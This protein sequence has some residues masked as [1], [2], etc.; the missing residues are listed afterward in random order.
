MTKFLV[1]TYNEHLLMLFQISSNDNS[2]EILENEVLKQGGMYC[3]LFI[4][5]PLMLVSEFQ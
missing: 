2:N 5:I 4:F 3:Y 1:T